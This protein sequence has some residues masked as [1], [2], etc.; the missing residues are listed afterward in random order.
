MSA[1]AVDYTELGVVVDGKKALD[2]DAPQLHEN[3]P[4]NIVLQWVCGKDAA[5][6]DAA[7]ANSEVRI[8]QGIINQR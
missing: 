6:V 8:S 1:I 4:N 7:L 2:P 5:T 3:A